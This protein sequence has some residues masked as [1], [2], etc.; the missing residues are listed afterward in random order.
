MLI[1]DQF[2]ESVLFQC[3]RCQMVGELFTDI[4][5]NDERYYCWRCLSVNRQLETNRMKERAKSSISQS[6]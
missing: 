2:S 4:V 3:D 6:H 5:E 1:L